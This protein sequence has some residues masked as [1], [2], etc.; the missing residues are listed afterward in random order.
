MT[1]TL[2]QEKYNLSES[3]LIIVEKFGYFS[4]I[5]PHCGHICSFLMSDH[6]KH[7]HFPWALQAEPGGHYYIVLSLYSFSQYGYTILHANTRTHIS[8]REFCLSPILI[9]LKTYMYYTCK[10]YNFTI[11][12]I[13]CC[14]LQQ[15]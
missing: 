2:R 14:V 5:K 10:S 4:F 8:I 13:S 1:L 6:P 7:V 3:Y 15:M 12:I 11:S 9:E